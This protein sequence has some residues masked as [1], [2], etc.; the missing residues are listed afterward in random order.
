MKVE[1]TVLELNQTWIVTDLPLGK[2]PVDCRYFYKIKYNSDG[3]IKRFKARLVAKGYTQEEGIDYSETFSPMA[4]LVT[5]RCLLSVAVVKR[6]RL[7][8]FDV[9]NAFL[10]EDLVEEI[11]M[12]KPLGYDKGGPRRVGKLLKSLYGLKQA[13][14]QWYAKFFASLLEFGFIQSKADYSLFTKKDGGSFMALLVCVDSVTH[15]KQFLNTS[16]KL[17]TWLFHGSFRPECLSQIDWKTL[18]LD[19]H[20]TRYIL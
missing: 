10:H 16:F 17:R 15:L 14:R 18:A 6:W 11:Y 9:N 4:K 7:Y 2:K 19:H 13:S 1:L 12:K 5:V 3:T 20:Q 8:Q